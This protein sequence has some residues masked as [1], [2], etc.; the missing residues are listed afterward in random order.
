MASGYSPAAG[1]ALRD[2]GELRAIW[3]VRP[4]KNRVCSGAGRE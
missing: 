4:L 3:G 2:P 1:V